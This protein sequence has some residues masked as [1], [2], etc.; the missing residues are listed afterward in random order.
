MIK[1]GTMIVGKNAFKDS[2]ELIDVG[3]SNSVIRIEEE[4]FSYCE[5][6]HQIN[7]PNLV[8]FVEKSTFEE[9]TCI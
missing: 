5:K 9:D 4:A 1:K 8:D 7:I 3:I 6:L 2:F